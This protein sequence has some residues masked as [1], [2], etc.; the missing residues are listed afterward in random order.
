MIQ[1]AYNFVALFSFQMKI[2]NIL[3]LS[4]WGLQK[5]ELPWEQIFKA[6]GVFPVKL[7]DCQISMVCC[8]N[9]PR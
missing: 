1:Q 7:L 5:I 6:V 8:A 2:T 3:K 9:W 4:G